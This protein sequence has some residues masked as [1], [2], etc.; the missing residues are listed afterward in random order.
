MFVDKPSLAEE[1]RLRTC[2]NEQPADSGKRRYVP[3]K[4][5][6]NSPRFKIVLAVPLRDDER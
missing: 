4:S 1:N 2:Y 6:F 5:C 3:G